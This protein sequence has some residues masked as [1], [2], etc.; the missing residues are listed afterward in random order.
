MTQYKATVVLVPP[1]ATK[2]QYLAI[3]DYQHQFGRTIARSF[4]DAATLMPPNNVHA[5]L[6][7]E[8][9]VYGYAT[10]TADEKAFLEA[11]NWRA[12]PL[13]VVGEPAQPPTPPAQPKPATG[14]DISHHQGNI[15]WSKMASSDADFLFIRCSNGLTADTRIDSYAPAARLASIPYSFYHYYQPG[16]DPIAQANMVIAAV[17]KHGVDLPVALDL[18]EGTNIPADYANRV[19]VCLKHLEAQLG[20]KPL[21]YT[22]SGYW[23]GTLKSPAWGASYPLWIAQW[24]TAAKPT[25]PGTWST[26][27]FWQYSNQ[28]DGAA[29]G[30]QSQRIDLNRTADLSKWLIPRKPP[31]PSPTAIDLYRFKVA[32]PDCWRVVRMPD[33]RQ[34]DVQDMDLGGGMFVRRKGNNGEWHRHNGQFFWLIHDTS[35]DVGDEGIPR[36]YTLYKNG[37]PGA[38]KSKVFQAVGEQWK[39]EGVHHVQFRAKADCRL[40]AENSGAASNSSIITRYEKNFTLNRYGQNLTFDEVIFEKTGVETQIY[41]RKDGRSCGWIGWSAPW[42]E[43]EPVEIHWNRGRLTVEPKRW[44]NWQ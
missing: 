21:I 1:V 14:A 10:L 25:L 30:V 2:A 28:G 41:G 23:I 3:A 35:P 6:E 17:N 38:P 39:E 7:S 5:A 26:W 27:A 8:I 19:L 31:T 18:E 36:V 15:Q 20:H 29:Y 44:C 32:D 12:T 9:I 34:E 22:S 43:S 13:P 24:T 42:G 37:V 11:Y 4:H 33:G 40:L 16:Q